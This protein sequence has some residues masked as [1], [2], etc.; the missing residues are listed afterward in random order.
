[1]TEPAQSPAAEARP[2]EEPCEQPSGDNRVLGG[3][4]VAGLPVCLGGLRQESALFEECA[5]LEAVEHRVRNRGDPL[6]RAEPQANEPI[7]ELREQGRITFDGTPGS[8]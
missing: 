7:D 8:P 1:R 4:D 5:E 3:R 6:F 2:D